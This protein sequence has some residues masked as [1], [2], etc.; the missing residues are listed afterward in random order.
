MI[1]MINVLHLETCYSYSSLYPKCVG[2]L[3]SFMFLVKY[4]ILQKY[5]HFSGTI[6]KFKE[7]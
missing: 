1:F 7:L 6:A 3:P 2:F 5:F 4:F